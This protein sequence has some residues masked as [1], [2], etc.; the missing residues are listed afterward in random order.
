MNGTADIIDTKVQNALQ[1]FDIDESSITAGSTITAMAIKI[2]ADQA[3]GGENA[4]AQSIRCVS[5]SCTGFGS[6][7]TTTSAATDYTQTHS[8]LSITDLSDIEIGGE[9][10]GGGVNKKFRIYRILVDITYTP[11]AGG[12]ANSSFGYI[13]GGLLQ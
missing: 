8:S 4:T 3:A 11:P 12:S 5:A 7:F 9:K 13:M 2:C 1:T 10:T 6:S